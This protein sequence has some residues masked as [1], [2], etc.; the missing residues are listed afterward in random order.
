M[1]HGDMVNIVLTS[2][3]AKLT[4]GFPL[5]S[6]ALLGIVKMENRIV[7]VWGQGTLAHEFGLLGLGLG[8]ACDW[9]QAPGNPI[10]AG[11]ALTP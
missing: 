2:W 7:V 9:K 10:P 6:L 8:L 4:G 1:V 3:V 5:E 11:F